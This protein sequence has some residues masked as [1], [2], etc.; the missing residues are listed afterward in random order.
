MARGEKN[1]DPLNE[2]DLDEA[3]HR[4]GAYRVQDPKAFSSLIRDMARPQVLSTQADR[5]RAETPDQLA[6]VKKE[7]DESVG[8]GWANYQF[9]QMLESREFQTN[10]ELPSE[11]LPRGA[12][13]D[14]SRRLN[15]SPA[16]ITRW[17]LGRAR[18]IQGRQLKS[19]ILTA[20]PYQ[21]RV[22]Q[23]C[24]APAG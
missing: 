9:R 11:P 17:T 19:L 7:T 12:L 6:R 18:W 3:D 4:R 13:L 1:S 8:G 5:L 21:L 23:R 10:L 15:C 20:S 16:T 2:L 22:L 24:I 14:L